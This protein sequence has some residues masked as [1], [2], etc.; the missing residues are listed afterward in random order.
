ML[1][2][3]QKLTIYKCESHSLLPLY[4]DVLFK[5]IPL[6]TGIWRGLKLKEDIEPTNL[7]DSLS[8]FIIYCKAFCWW[9]W[10]WWSFSR[11]RL[12]VPPWTVAWQ[13]PLSMGFSRQEYWSGLPF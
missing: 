9:W 8:S 13:V 1:R 12:F 3:E 5:V 4:L 6:R 7:K 10:W 11:V 2:E